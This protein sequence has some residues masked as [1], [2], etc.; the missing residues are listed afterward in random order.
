M[1]P[2]RVPLNFSLSSMIASE[3]FGVEE[4]WLDM[5]NPS[6]AEDFVAHSP[7]LR[8]L[9]LVRFPCWIDNS[10]FLQV[11]GFELLEDVYNFRGSGLAG[12]IALFFL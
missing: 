6:F 5:K 3:A 4:G 1:D 11:L 12:A 8:S 2:Q 7:F 10:P 9:Q